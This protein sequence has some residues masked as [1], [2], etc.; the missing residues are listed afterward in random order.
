M[1]KVQQLEQRVALLENLVMQVVK[2]DKYYF[3]KQLVFA[4][5]ANVSFSTGT[6][7]KIG[8]S[9]GQKIG[10]FNKAPVSQQ[11]SGAN[12]TNN[13][14]SGGTDDTVDN[15]G[16]AATDTTA[17]KLTDTRNAVYQLARK[18]KQINDA[19]RLYG[20]LS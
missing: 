13:V 5:G 16:A 17:A 18:V 14:T 11:T 9:T 19:L 12:V 10:F 20:L 15:I 8:T 6:G 4:D 3:G 2:S 7:T 1:D